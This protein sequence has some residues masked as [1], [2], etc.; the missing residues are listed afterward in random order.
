M[1]TLVVITAVNTIYMDPWLCLYCQKAGMFQKCSW[2]TVYLGFYTYPY[3]V[4]FHEKPYLTARVL[5]AISLMAQK[6]C[7]FMKSKMIIS[8]LPK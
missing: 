2:S 1:F 3:F 6:R 8:S 5:E 7:D 4:L